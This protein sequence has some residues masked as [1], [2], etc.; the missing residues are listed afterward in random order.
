MREAFRG[1]GSRPNPTAQRGTHR[2]SRAQLAHPGR[3]V[4]RRRPEPEGHRALHQ[5]PP[6]PPITTGTGPTEDPPSVQSPASTFPRDGGPTELSLGPASTTPC[7]WSSSPEPEGPEHATSTAPVPRG[8]V[9][10]VRGLS[11]HSPSPRKCTG[12]PS[13]PSQGRVRPRPYTLSAA[14]WTPD[15]PNFGGGGNGHAGLSGKAPSPKKFDCADPSRPHPQKNR[16]H[17]AMK[18]SLGYGRSQRAPPKTRPFF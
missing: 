9:K 2:A 5:L 6:A 10:P 12:S 7:G 8:R 1:E 4:R 14:T 17:W 13:L 15:T 3:F 18:R 11:G 16:H